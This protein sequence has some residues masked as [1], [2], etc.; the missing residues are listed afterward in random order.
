[1]RVRLAAFVAATLVACVSAGA[2]AEPMDPALERLVGKPHADGSFTPT[3]G[4]GADTCH[5]GGQWANDASGATV[6]TACSPDNAAFKR[7]ISQY[8][9]AF[10]PTAMHSARTT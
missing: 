4:V 9:F 8:A 2:S 3:P 6:S 1:M 5:P 10:A 7:L